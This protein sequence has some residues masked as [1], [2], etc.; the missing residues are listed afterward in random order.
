MSWA[1]ASE[2]IRSTWA[3]LAEIA[4]DPV[5]F[6]FVAPE[7]LKARR[8]DGADLPRGEKTEHRIGDS[9]FVGTATRVPLPGG[10]L[11]A[12]LGVDAGLL[13]AL[14]TGEPEVVFDTQSRMKS[15]GPNGDFAAREHEGRSV[16]TTDAG[17]ALLLEAY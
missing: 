4:D 16:S 13:D 2:V 3:K 14:A 11:R 10:E 1:S 9:V 17:T 5:L 8:Y 12:F 7:K 6:D 15:R